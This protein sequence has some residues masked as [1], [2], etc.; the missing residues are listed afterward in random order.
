MANTAQL[1]LISRQRTEEGEETITETSLQAE[2][3]ERNGSLYLLYQESLEGTE[4]VIRTCIKLKG[5]LLEIT[6]KGAVSTR[7]VFEEGREHLSDYIT[8]Y[9]HLKIG[10]RTEALECMQ[11]GEKMEIH[12]RYCL[13][14]QGEAFSYCDMSILLSPA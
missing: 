7:M 14:S 9:G 13:T 1:T 10:I 6:R 8:P 11:Q 4:D 2:Y 12:A 5:R 3:Y